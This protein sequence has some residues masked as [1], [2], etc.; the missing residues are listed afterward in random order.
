MIITRINNIR[1]IPGHIFETFISKSKSS[2][3][4][5]TNWLSPLGTSTDIIRAFSLRNK[6]LKDKIFIAQEESYKL[7]HQLSEIAKLYP[8][9][10]TLFDQGIE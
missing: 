3:G 2:R 8:E 5:S 4:L 7:Y 9:L 1:V 6:T 10:H